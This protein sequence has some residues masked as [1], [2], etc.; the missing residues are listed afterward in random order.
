M[1][2][3]PREVTIGEV[4]LAEDK[5]VTFPAE[6]VSTEEVK[7]KVV[8]FPEVELR[9]E[10][11]VGEDMD[12]WFPEVVSIE[13]VVLSSSEETDEAKVVRFPRVV[14][15]EEPVVIEPTGVVTGGKVVRFLDV[16][17]TDVMVLGPSEEIAA[18]KVV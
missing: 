2:R 13:E 14:S 17:F 18:D 15:L 8:R 4:L 1:V 10:G 5:V 7:A 9:D 6:V 3:F 16:V 11:V 12:V